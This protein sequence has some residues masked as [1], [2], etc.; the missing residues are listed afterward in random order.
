MS[1]AL[2]SAKLGGSSARPRVVYTVVSRVECTFH[3]Q[4]HYALPHLPERTYASLFIPSD[5]MFVQVDKEIV[6]KAKGMEKRHNAL[7]MPN[8]ISRGGL[9]LH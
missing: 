2:C 9:G 4:W 7:H 1:L 8:P 5:S 3:A 6:N